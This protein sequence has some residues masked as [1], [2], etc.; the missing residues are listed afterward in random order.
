M[1][2]FLSVLVVLLLLVAGIGYYR[3]WFHAQ[4]NDGNGQATVTVTV[5]KDKITQDKNSARQEV[6]D[7][8]HK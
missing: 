3:G 7:L 6:Q 8:G 5:N 1:I 4:S 2:R